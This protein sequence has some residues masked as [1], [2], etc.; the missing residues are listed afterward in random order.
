VI[1]NVG[2][3]VCP[4]EFRVGE[5]A[6]IMVSSV[7]EGEEKPLKY[8]LMFRA[9][10]LVLVNKIDLLPHLDFDLDRFLYNLDQVHPGRRSDPRE[11]EDA[12]GDR[13]VARLAGEGSAQPRRLTFESSAPDDVVDRALRDRTQA[14]RDFFEAEADR[15][16]RVCHRMAERFARGGR[17]IAFGRSPSARS[18]A[19]HVA[20]GIRPPGDRRKRALPAIG[21]A[22]EGG[23]VPEQVE[24]LA[25]PDDIAYRFSR[26]RTARTSRPARS[27][28]ARHRARAR[29][30]HA[31]LRAV[32]A[33][34]EFEPPRPIRRS[35]RS[36][37]RR[38]TTCSGSWC[39]SSSTTA[40]CSRAAARAHA[41]HRRV[42]LPLSVPVG[43][44][45][46]LET[47]VADVRRS[48]LAKSRD[49]GELREQT[50]TENRDTLLAAA[51]AC[52]RPRRR[53]PPAGARQRRLGHRRDGRGG[54]LPAPAEARWSARRAL[55]LTE[56]TA[57]LTAIAERHRHRG[58]LRAAGDRARREG[59]APARDLHERELVERDRR[60]LSEA[61]SPRL[62]TDRD[63]RLRR[64]PGGGRGTGRPR[65]R[66]ALEHIPRIQEAQASA[67][68][69]LE[70][71]RRVSASM[72]RVR[73]R[74][75][76]HGAR[77]SASA[78]TCTAWRTRWEWPGTC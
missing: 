5:D 66:D 53:R 2:N 54:R 50:L 18:D 36:S 78:R 22:G 67:Y 30:P 13:G 60:A 29:L 44:E 76:G 12:G 17:L 23:S 68:H 56:D 38:S 58:D 55:D 1:E 24:L 64:R 74:D 20:V 71:A 45:H 69:V 49:V 7:T 62:V 35:A 15:L 10:E 63:G 47:V 34:W 26:T 3:L 52:A 43:G 27:R 6:R 33:E 77:A 70:G 39:T 61:A 46:D 32:G 72:S 73:A 59:D 11:R 42:E 75:R 25:E 19:R 48:V 21:L 51:E 40:A 31:R 16:A 14:N 41:R 8:P 28:R 37:S 9:C 4:A 57:I 65:D